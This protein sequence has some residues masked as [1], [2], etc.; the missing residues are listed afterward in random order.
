MFT[1]LRVRVAIALVLALLSIPAVGL[2]VFESD[3]SNTD[4][5]AFGLRHSE[6]G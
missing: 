6:S 1:T 4:T 2:A 5:Y 3:M